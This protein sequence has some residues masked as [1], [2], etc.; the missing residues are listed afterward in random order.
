MMPSSQVRAETFRKHSVPQLL[1]ADDSPLQRKALCSFLRD[2][3][4]AVAEAS[5]GH[6]TLAYLQQCEV[7]LLVLDLHMPNT[8]GFE[9]LRYLQAHRQGLP[10]I[11]VSGMPVDE[12]QRSMRRRHQA[13]LP[14]LLLKPID[15][16]QLIQVVEM[17]LSGQLQAGW[18]GE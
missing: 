10:V 11:L 8:D 2:Q 3:G 1:V 14:P 16:E 18:R 15:P 17:H 5:D 7:D 4:Y 6:E 13:D 9:V 12:I